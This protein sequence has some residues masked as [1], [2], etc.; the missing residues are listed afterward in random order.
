MVKVVNFTLCVFYPNK[1]SK[2]QHANTK[3]DLLV[4]PPLPE[5]KQPDPFTCWQ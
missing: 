5:S 1:K 2:C 4:L 3:L